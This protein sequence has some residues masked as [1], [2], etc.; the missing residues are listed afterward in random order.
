MAGHRETADEPAQTI[1]LTGPVVSAN[2]SVQAMIHQAIYTVVE[3]IKLS[4]TVVTTQFLQ[5]G[6]V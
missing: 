3:S 4:I 1:L 5:L 6:T 2:Y